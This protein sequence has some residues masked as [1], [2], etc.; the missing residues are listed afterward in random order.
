MTESSKP[1]AAHRRQDRR[2]VKEFYLRDVI[3]CPGQGGPH[4][5]FIAI[6]VIEVAP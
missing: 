6:E 4:K 3:A 5:R 2:D 1:H